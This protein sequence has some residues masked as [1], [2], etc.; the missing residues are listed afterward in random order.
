VHGFELLD[1]HL[2]INGR[3]F[4]FLMSEQLLDEADVGPAFEHVSRATMAQDVTGSRFANLSLFDELA[5]HPAD[6]VGIERLAV[7][8]EEQRFFMRS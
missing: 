2:R 6:D 5:H 1:A 3:G 7:A 8:G 4:E